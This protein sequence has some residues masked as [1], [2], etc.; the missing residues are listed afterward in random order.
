MNPLAAFILAAQTVNVAFRAAAPAFAAIA[1][2]ACLG[3]GY[4]AGYERSPRDWSKPDDWHR[5][6]L[7]GVLAGL[8]ARHRPSA[9]NEVEI[10]R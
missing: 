10:V 2:A 7:R 4:R 5:G 1:R 6:Y 3:L 9:G 8:R